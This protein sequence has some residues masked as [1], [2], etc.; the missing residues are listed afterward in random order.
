MA[1]SVSGSLYSYYCVAHFSPAGNTNGLFTQNV[2]PFNNSAYYSLTTKA[3]T[4]TKPPT[5]V[6]G[7]RTLPTGCLTAFRQAVLNRTNVLR[8]SHNSRFATQSATLDAAALT[9]AQKLMAG[10]YPLSPSTVG[11]LRYRKM[12]YAGTGVSTAND[13]ARNLS[14]TLLKLAF[15]FNLIYKIKKKLNRASFHTEIEIRI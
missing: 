9:T 13:C 14:F 11:E 10:Q 2:K 1:A 8:A 4:T 15:I 3:A 12:F 6:A 5:T 7:V